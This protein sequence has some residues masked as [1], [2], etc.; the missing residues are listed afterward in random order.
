MTHMHRKGDICTGHGCWPPRPSIQGSPDV[1]TN[2]IKQHRI[3]DAWA[4]HGVPPCPPHGSVQCAGSPNVFANTL[5]V[6]RKGDAVC[7]GSACATHSP[8]VIANGP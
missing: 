8:N 3:T 7:C 4:V 2:N 6:A 5:A 1:F